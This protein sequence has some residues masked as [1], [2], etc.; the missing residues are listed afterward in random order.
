MAPGMLGGPWCHHGVPAATTGSLVLSWIDVPIT[1]ELRGSRALVSSQI[2]PSMVD[3]SSLPLQVFSPCRR[4][5]P[6]S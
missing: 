3:R 4:G 6:Q 2:P 5:W 1:C